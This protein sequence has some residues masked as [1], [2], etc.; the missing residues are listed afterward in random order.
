MYGP[1]HL[2]FQLFGKVGTSLCMD[3]TI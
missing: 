1:N 2:V 3:P